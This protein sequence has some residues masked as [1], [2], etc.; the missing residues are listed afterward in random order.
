MGT[1][2]SLHTAVALLHPCMLVMKCAHWVSIAIYHTRSQFMRSRCWNI[3]HYPRPQTQYSTAY[4]RACTLSVIWISAGFFSPRYPL[5][6]PFPCIPPGSF[7][8]LQ[9]RIDS[10][11]RIG[12]SSW[13]GW[14]L[15]KYAFSPVPVFFRH[16]PG[17][18]SGAAT[19]QFSSFSSHLWLQ[20]AIYSVLL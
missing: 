9:A 8:Q 2:S 3:C 20:L 1:L 5:S 17:S 15:L 4:S 11:D 7:L 6:T 14:N 13:P 12:V 10:T 16:P 19:L 18:R